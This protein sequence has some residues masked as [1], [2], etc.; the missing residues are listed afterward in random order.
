MNWEK[1]QAVVDNGKILRIQKEN[2]CCREAA[3]N[4]LAGYRRKNEETSG[5][6]K[7]RI[8]A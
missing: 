1:R 4:L 5:E 7:G 3:I 6:G 2:G 8:E